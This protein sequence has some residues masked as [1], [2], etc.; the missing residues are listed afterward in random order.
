MQAVPQPERLLLP[1]Q[2]R[3]HPLEARA[4]RMQY[5]GSLAITTPLFYSPLGV[6]FGPSVS[7]RA[8]TARVR[9]DPGISYHAFLFPA[10]NVLVAN[11][12]VPECAL[13]LLFGYLR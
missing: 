11:R 9:L 7:A 1:H 13:A 2:P 5:R 12:K 6:P 4:R 8:V 3:F 10:V